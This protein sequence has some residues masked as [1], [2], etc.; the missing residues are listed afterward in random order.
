AVVDEL[1]SRDPALRPATAEE[2][3]ALLEPFAASGAR[4]PKP[5]DAKSKAALVLEVL[6]GKTT[7]AEA[8]AR[9]GLAV[10]EVERWRQRFLEGAERALDPSADPTLQ[11][12]HADIGAQAMEIKALKQQLVGITGRGEVA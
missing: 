1:R 9:E 5:W 2:A 6:Q 7:A 10:E 4:E 8:C 3:I 11:E 12:L